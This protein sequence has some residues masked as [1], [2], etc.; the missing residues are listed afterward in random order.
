M[1]FFL[2]LGLAGCLSRYYSRVRVLREPL[3][4][5]VPTLHARI[6]LLT[7]VQ[8]HLLRLLDIMDLTVLKRM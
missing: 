4:S 7:A 1:W 6:H 2:N 3:P 5:L 8:D